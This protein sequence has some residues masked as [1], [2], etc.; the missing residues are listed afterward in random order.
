VATLKL[1]QRLETRE[2]QVLLDPD[3]KPG[4]YRVTLVIETALGRSEPAQ[5]EVIVTET[6]R[7]PIGPLTP[8]RPVAP[9]GPLAPVRPAPIARVTEIPGADVA[10]AIPES[11]PKPKS[12]AKKTPKAKT[13]AKPPAKPPVKPKRK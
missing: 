7:T 5:L 3:L 1:G 8:V 13:P 12:K 2:P 10:L 11:T 6:R 4:R 9:I